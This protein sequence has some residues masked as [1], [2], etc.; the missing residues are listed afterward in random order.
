MTDRRRI[1]EPDV[2]INSV[3]NQIQEAKQLISIQD[4]K[5]RIQAFMDLY[6]VKSEAE[7][8][9]SVMEDIVL[10]K[11]TD[12]K[13]LP[14]AK[15]T[16]TAIY[17]DY[18]LITGKS[19]KSAERYFKKVQKRI[20]NIHNLG[21][22][23]HHAAAVGQDI[24]ARMYADLEKLEDIIKGLY[25]DIEDLDD[26][27]KDHKEK[28]NSLNYKITQILSRK[29]KL[30]EQLMKYAKD[31]GMDLS[32]KNTQNIINEQKNEILAQKFDNDAQWQKADVA[33]RYKDLSPEDKRKALI[34]A[35]SSDK[36]ITETVE[37][38]FSAKVVDGE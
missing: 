6:D 1:E 9:E 21:M 17:N 27:V 20:K 34:Q 36:G 23:V 30:Y 35:I 14:T 8:Q 7:A 5:E 4:P 26:N 2:D 16:K 24:V 22:V 38:T 15:T 3:N 12:V 28:L 37:S 11:M 10:S 33:I 29:E 31:F 19:R 32:I 13:Y 25:I 18:C